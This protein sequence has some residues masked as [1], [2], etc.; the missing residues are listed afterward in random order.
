[1]EGYEIKPWLL[2]ALKG[3]YVGKF[4]DFPNWKY[5]TLLTEDF[6]KMFGFMDFNNSV[7]QPSLKGHLCES[8]QCPALN[9]CLEENH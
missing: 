1:M 6:G 3:E 9:L 4:T 7:C 2:F 5:C 8:W